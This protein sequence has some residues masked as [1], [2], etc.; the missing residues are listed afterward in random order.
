[1]GRRLALLGSINVGGNR[2]TMGDLVGA[3]TRHGFA[4]VETV[5][6]RT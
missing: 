4:D 3:L 5:A 6:D 2:I 1:M